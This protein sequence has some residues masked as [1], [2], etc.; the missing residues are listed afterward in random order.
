M[1]V[2]HPCGIESIA[3][4]LF[5]G[6]SWVILFFIR[7]RPRSIEANSLFWLSSIKQIGVSGSRVP[8]I[9]KMLVGYISIITMVGYISIIKKTLKHHFEQL[10]FESGQ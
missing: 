3:N 8:R 4:L 1:G 5:V 6:V 9:Y 7:A 2:S 10:R